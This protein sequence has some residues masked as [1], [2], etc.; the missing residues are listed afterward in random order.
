MIWRPSESDFVLPWIDLK[1]LGKSKIDQGVTGLDFSAWDDATSA[2]LAI[3]LTWWNYASYCNCK[4][5]ITG[6]NE[7]FTTLAKL[8]GVEFLVTGAEDVGH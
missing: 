4:I 3:I 6:L 7:T 1:R 5:E 2:H 8:G